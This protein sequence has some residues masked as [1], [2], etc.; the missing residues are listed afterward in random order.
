[1]SAVASYLVK[2]LGLPAAA[3]IFLLEGIGL[4][5]PVEIP[6]F[7]VGMR[8]TDDLHSYWKMVLIMWAS[9]VIGNTLGYYIGYYGGRPLVL[10]FLAWFRIKPEHWGRMEVWFRRHG[11]KLL[12]GTRWINWGFAQNIWLAG[13]TRVPKARFFLVMIVN[14]LLWAMGWIWLVHRARYWMIA[15][16]HKQGWA[17]LLRFLHRST[18]RLGLLAVVL[19]VLGVGLWLFVRWWRQQKRKL[20]DGV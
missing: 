6:L 2:H 19:A 8:V 9:T 5:I 15:H 11:L 18:V 10:K 20:K 4:P 3:F 13:I 12:V 7:M 14:D 1:M 17:T 16:G